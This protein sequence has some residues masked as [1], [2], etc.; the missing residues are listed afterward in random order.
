[1][2][3]RDII[4]G[5]SPLPTSA[6]FMLL[7][8]ANGMVVPV[9]VAKL[10]DD[11]QV[12]IAVAIREGKSWTSSFP[13][14]IRPDPIVK[15]SKP[16]QFKGNKLVV[17]ADWETAKDSFTPWRY[18]DSLVG[19]EFIEWTAYFNQ[20]RTKHEKSSDRGREI[21]QSRCHFCHSMRGIGGKFGPD[22]ATAVSE[23]K[24]AWEALYNKVAGPKSAA[25]KLSHSMPSLNSF[26]KSDAKA[27]VRWINVARK[28][29]AGDYVPTYRNTFK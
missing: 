12:F 15:D 29:M 4:G 2:Y 27:L 18:V 9:A 26:S 6:D 23:D 16:I 10:R 19:I 11:R 5:Y 1:L 21:Y 24:Q 8:M 22:F 25:E 14:S 17:G 20:F 7:H 3:L 28:D 13:A